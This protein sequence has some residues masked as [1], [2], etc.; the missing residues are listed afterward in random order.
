M[1]S[2]IVVI[3]KYAGSIAAKAGHLVAHAHFAY[4]FQAMILDWVMIYTPS[5]THSTFDRKLYTSIGNLQP[6]DG[7]VRMILRVRA[8]FSTAAVLPK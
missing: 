2:K 6:P 4:D 7:L 1:R 8:Q 5:A 3:T